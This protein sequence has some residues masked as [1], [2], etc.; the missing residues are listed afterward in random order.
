MTDAP[1]TIAFVGTAEPGKADAAR[2]YEDEVLALLPDHGARVIYRGHRT[3]G[4][5]PTLP[6]EVHLLWF[7]SQEAFQAFLADV[8]RHAAFDR[9]GEVFT[10][11]VVVELDEV[12]GD[13]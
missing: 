1:F 5:D 11:K 4:Q 6:V 2:A 9:H 8:R 13:P 10:Q 3:A 12:S 7:P